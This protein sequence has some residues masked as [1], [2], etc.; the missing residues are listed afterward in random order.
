MTKANQETNQLI[1]HCIVQRLNEIESLEYLANHG[2]NIKKT[3]FYKL[4]K[5]IKNS[6]F[7]RMREIADTGHIDYHLDAIDT[8]NWAKKELVKCAEEEKDP[9]KRAEILTQIINLEPYFT[10]YVN[11]TKEVMTNKIASEQTADQEIL[12]E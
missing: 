9:H 2:H 3:T 10:E 6:R 8:F 12:T 4:K 1:I 7:S 11:E 5:R